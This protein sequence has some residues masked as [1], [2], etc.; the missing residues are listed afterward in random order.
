MAG[1][2]ITRYQVQHNILAFNREVLLYEY[3]GAL[4]RKG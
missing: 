2:S 1:Y 3:R 4:R